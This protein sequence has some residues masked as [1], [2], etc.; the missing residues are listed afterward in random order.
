MHKPIDVFL[1]A[2]LILMVPTEA[3]RGLRANL[4]HEDL[5]MLEFFDLCGLV[6]DGAS[7]SAANRPG[8]S[9][10]D[11]CVNDFRLFYE[12]SV[13]MGKMRNIEGHD[14]QDDSVR[15]NFVK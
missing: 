8:A 12:V 4:A 15:C 1:V 3:R 11:V 6:D 5:D 2:Q 7:K 10:K 14:G 13:M 9:D